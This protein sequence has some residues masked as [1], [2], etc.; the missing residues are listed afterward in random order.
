MGF[1]WLKN[2]GK[3]DLHPK[4]EDALHEKVQFFYTILSLTADAAYD[5]LGFPDNYGCIKTG[6][7]Q[8]VYPK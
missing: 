3:I 7:C 1:L 5:P 2:K 6:R 4:I 8:S